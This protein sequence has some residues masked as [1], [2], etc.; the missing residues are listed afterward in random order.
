MLMKVN[1]PGSEHTV[2]DWIIAP[3]TLGVGEIA[4]EAACNGTGCKFVRSGVGTASIAKAPK[5]YASYH[6]TEAY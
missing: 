1:V 3:I 2:G 4:D 6:R 5:R